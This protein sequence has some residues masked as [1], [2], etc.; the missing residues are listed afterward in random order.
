MTPS[1]YHHRNR[2]DG[3]RKEEPRSFSLI[4]LPGFVVFNERAFR[5]STSFRRT[6]MKQGVHHL[7][8]SVV[9]R[10]E[11][12]EEGKEEEETTTRRD[13]REVRRE[14]H[15]HIKLIR[16]GISSSISSISCT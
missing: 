2:F 1:S 15:F 5:K 8:G 12:G 7:K 16:I 9:R 13:E 14:T 4:P 6:R 10:V 11:G 3:R